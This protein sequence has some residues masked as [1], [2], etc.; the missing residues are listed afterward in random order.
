MVVWSCRWESCDNCA[1][2]GNV[3]IQET[4]EYLHENCRN[5]DENDLDLNRMTLN[6]SFIII[7]SF[8]MFAKRIEI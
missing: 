8:S 2:Y 4:L 3:C 7:E 5:F 1:G 6:K